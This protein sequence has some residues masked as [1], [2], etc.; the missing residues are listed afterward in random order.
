MARCNRGFTLIEMM[1]VV[2]II[3]A[4]SSLVVM[5]MP[6][7]SPEKQSREMLALL[8]DAIPMQRMEAMAQG[9]LFGLLITPRGYQF[10][11]QD[12]TAPQGW[13]PLVSSERT[14]PENVTLQLAQQDLLLDEMPAGEQEGKPQLL[15]F[16][17]GEVTPFELTA[18]EQKKAVATLSVSESGETQLRDAQAAP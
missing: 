12:A 2:V 14:F 1:L 17:G 15:F 11:V 6:S 9:A 13:Q 18:L 3:A 7:H 10:M 16:P 4:T 5:A 8:A